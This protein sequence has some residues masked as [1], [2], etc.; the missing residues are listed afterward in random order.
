MSARTH[1]GRDGLP[2]RIPVTVVAGTAT[3]AGPGIV[4][5]RLPPARHAHAEGV[6][7]PA[8]AA[9]G[10]V[11]LQLHDLLVRAQRGE[12]GPFSAVVVET[13]DNL[14]GPVAD[15]LVPGRLPATALRDHTVARRFYLAEGA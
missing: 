4:T 8:C 3:E 2:A 12:I 10:D 15:A 11:R 5:I 1:P 7:C 9:R 13:G 6:F 14:P